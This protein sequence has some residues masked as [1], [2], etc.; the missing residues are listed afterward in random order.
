M[1]GTSPRAV[2][3]FNPTL[4][5]VR[6][7]IER[8]WLAHEQRRVG[9]ASSPPPD[10]D[11]L[12]QALKQ[13]WANHPVATHPLFDFLEKDASREQ[14]VAFFKSD[15]ALN[16]RFFDL[17]LYSMIGSREG[18]RRELAQNLWDES[19]RGEAARSHVSLFQRLLEAVGVGRARDNHARE[20]GWEGLAGYNLFMLTC[21]N[22]QHYFKL[23]GIMA[24]TELLDPLQ[25]EKLTRGCR[26]VGLG[27]S[28]ELEYYDEHVTI[29]VIHG[30]GWLSNVIKPIVGETPQVSSDIL[31]GAALRLV[32][33]NDYYDSLYERLAG[34]RLTR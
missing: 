9:V 2:N 26:R 10:A 29:D 8:V 3:Q 31:T 12:V 21:L 34:L 22:R 20:L 7:R 24:M 13:L 6:N 23:L 14:I 19:G 18:V 27:G 25:Y 5:R 28:N 16:I 17:I 30:D 1:D 11:S 32:T 33:C 15:S 4:T